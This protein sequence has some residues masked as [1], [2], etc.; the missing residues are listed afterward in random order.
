MYGCSMSVIE[1]RGF[2]PPFCSQVGPGIF[3]LSSSACK[4]GEALSREPDLWSFGSLFLYDKGL[5]VCLIDAAFV[6]PSA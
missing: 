1:Y 4:T 6:A 5:V 3:L 2:R